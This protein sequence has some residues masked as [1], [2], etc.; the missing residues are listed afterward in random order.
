MI[1][2]YSGKSESLLCVCYEKGHSTMLSMKHVSV[3][4]P[5]TLQIFQYLL[6][7]HLVLT[8]NPNHRGLPVVHLGV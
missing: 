3:H 4:V 8:L 6:R 2:S 1:T 7:N 5:F